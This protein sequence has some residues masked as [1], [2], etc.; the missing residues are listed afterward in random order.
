MTIYPCLIRFVPEPARNHV[1]T[2]E[3]VSL[4]LAARARTHTEPP[5]VIGEEKRMGRPGL[6]EPLAYRASTLTTELPSHTVDN[7]CNRRRKIL[8]TSPG[9]GSNPDRPGRSQTL[10]RVAIKTGLYSKAVQVLIY[11]DPVTMCGQCVNL[12][13]HVIFS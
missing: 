9:R 8:R 6:P 5:N 1:G 13:F 12:T 2:D 11:L 3:T 7:K 10:Y 4:L